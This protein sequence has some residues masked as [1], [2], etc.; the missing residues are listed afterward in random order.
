MLS[1]CKSISWFIDYAASG[2]PDL[3]K[4]LGEARKLFEKGTRPEAK[5]VLVLI[6]DN[7]SPTADQ[8]IRN[9]AQPIQDSG[10]KIIAVVIGK[11]GDSEQ[12]ENAASSKQDVI[13]VSKNKEPGDVAREIMKKATDGKTNLFTCK[14]ELPRAKRTDQEKIIEYIVFVFCNAKRRD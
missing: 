7:R 11:E 13:S 9:I 2:E 3:G 12:L 6:T 10:I 14:A 4:A 8:E 1:C 5:K